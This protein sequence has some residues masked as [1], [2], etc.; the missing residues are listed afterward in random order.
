MTSLIPDQNNGLESEQW[1]TDTELNY[2]RNITP[3]THLR[4]HVR[5]IQSTQIG[6]FCDALEIISRNQAYSLLQLSNLE[7]LFIYS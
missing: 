3:T 2:S 1:W 4:D 6:Q 7:I 5:G